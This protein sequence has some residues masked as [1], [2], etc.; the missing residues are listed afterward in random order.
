M[1]QSGRFSDESLETRD[2]SDNSGISHIRHIIRS[3]HRLSNEGQ[4]ALGLILSKLQAA[5]V[6]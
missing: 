2:S 1:A 6:L 3:Y 5:D 4:S